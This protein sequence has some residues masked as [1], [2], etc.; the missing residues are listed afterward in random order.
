MAIT[1]QDV[2]REAGVSRTTVS[3]VLNGRGSRISAETAQRVLETAQR[4]GY[5]PNISARRL[6][7]RQGRSQT[8]CIGFVMNTIVGPATAPYYTEVM[9]GVQLEMHAH[10]YHLVLGVA[11]QTAAEKLAYL[12]RLTSAA[13]DGWILGDVMEDE[14]IA[15][16]RD[17]SV[18]TVIVGGGTV[19]SDL[20]CIYPDDAEAARQ[21]TRHLLSLGHR[22]FAFVADCLYSTSAKTR[23]L[24]Y[25]QA[26]EE[27]GLSPEAGSAYGVGREYK[28]IA[29]WFRETA[30][31]GQAPTAVMAIDDRQAL[32]LIR[33]AQEQG[34]VIP[35]D[36]SVAG[37]DDI[38]P[39]GH[40]EPALTTVRMPMRAMGSVAFQRLLD[41]IHHPE[42]PPTKMML[43]VELVVRDSTAPPACARVESQDRAP[44]QWVI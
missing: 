29:A 16:L 3:L 14:I 8:F 17:A 34:M 10:G 7:S 39:S 26:L 18:P 20:D 12:R 11:F 4:L 33:T 38:P 6:R 43:P 24:G 9:N 28:G 25:R 44:Q 5:Y 30:L 19:T 36:L 32:A 41:R 35:R 2:S 1:I 21:V 37:F 15:Y 42:L 40:W 27:H 23:L 31:S 13:V 22:R